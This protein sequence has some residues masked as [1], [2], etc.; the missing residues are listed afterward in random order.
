MSP[1]PT[2]WRRSAIAAMPLTLFVSSCSNEGWDPTT[3]MGRPGGGDEVKYIARSDGTVDIGTLGKLSKYIRAQRRLNRS[4]EQILNALAQKEIGGYRIERLRVLEQKRAVAAKRHQTQIAASESRYRARVAKIQAS[5]APE[6]PRLL[7]T[8]KREFQAETEQQ[9]ATMNREIVL[10]DSEI[11]A[12][13]SKTYLVPVRD[14]A[15][16]RDRSVV[17]IDSSNRIK[18]SKIYQIDRSVVDLAKVLA[19]EQPDVAVLTAVRP[20]ALPSGQ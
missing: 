16:S 5:P 17:L 11:K 9:K 10:I 18:D 14:S 6:Q 15:G 7:E 12:E 1:C 2:V 8:A 19:S 20:L 3:H 13:R 4:E